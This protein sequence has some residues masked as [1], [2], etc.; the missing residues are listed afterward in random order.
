MPSANKAYPGSI[1]G[2]SLRMLLKEFSSLNRAVELKGVLQKSLGIIKKVMDS[3]ASSLILLDEDSQ[4]LVVSIPSGP[5][6]HEIQGIRIS[7]EQ[8]V[9]GWVLEND[10]PYFSN[11]PKETEIFAG[12]LSEN[13]TTESIICV[14]LSGKNGKVIGVLEAINRKG[15]RGFSEDDIPVFEALSEHVA[16][17]IERTRELENLQQRVEDKEIM[18]TEV[19]HRIKNNLLTLTAL[20]EMEIPE[21]DEVS[22][23]VLQKTCARIDSMAEIHDLL[24]HNDLQKEIDLGEYIGRLT[25]KIS[26]MLANPSQD[27]SVKIEAESVQVDSERCM[28]CGLL[29]NELLVNAYKHAFKDDVVTGEIH[30]DLVENEEVIRLEVADNGEGLKEDFSLGTKESVGSWLIDVLLRKLEASMEI[31][32]EGGASFVISFDQ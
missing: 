31:D 1:S 3:E 29:L 32:S 10:Q 26:S 2:D 14:P 24:Y 28:C 6:R 25:K 23:E 12:E 16:H 27:I 20:I 17:T 21:V 9:A 19:S 5:V 4:E 18:L 22:R 30:I 15:G 8:G 13:F 7:R 11:S